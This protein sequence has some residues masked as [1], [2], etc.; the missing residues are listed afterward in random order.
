MTCN[1]P[2]LTDD[3]ERAALQTWVDLPWEE[4]LLTP[5]PLERL[6]AP[7]DGCRGDRRHR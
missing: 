5:V 7:L 6:R 1:D 4:H 2:S 3:E